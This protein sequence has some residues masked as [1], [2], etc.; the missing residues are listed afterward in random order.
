MWACRPFYLDVRLP[1]DP[2]VAWEAIASYSDTISAEATVQLLRLEG[3]QAR[4]V[5]DTA[6]LGEAR[7]C[8]IK[9]PAELAHRARWLL[10]SPQLSDAELD[11]LATGSL[12]DGD[13]SS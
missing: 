4:V 5:T 12:G 6:I 1:M 13:A 2:V 9:V 10:V 11:Y 3:V 7:R 8:E